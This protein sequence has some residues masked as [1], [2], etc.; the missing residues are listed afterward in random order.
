MPDPLIL[1]GST[2]ILRLQHCFGKVAYIMGVSCRPTVEVHW[3]N[4][5]TTNQ[6]ESKAKKENFVHFN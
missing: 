1:K 6:Q 3:L 5:A 4:C 2:H